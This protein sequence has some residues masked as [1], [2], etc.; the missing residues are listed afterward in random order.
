MLIK[1]KRGTT[2]ERSYKRS[3][4]THR[5]P[6][7]KIHCMRTPRNFLKLISTIYFHLL[8]TMVLISRRGTPYELR[9]D[10]TKLCV[11]LLQNIIYVRTPRNLLKFIPAID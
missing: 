7:S 3:K 2:Y 11:M 10:V 5:C 1:T 6:L 4:V 8:I 9:Y